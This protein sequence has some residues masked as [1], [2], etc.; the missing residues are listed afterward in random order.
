MAGE[1]INR[2]TDSQKQKILFRC[3][4]FEIALRWK[5]KERKGKEKERKTVFIQRL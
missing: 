4:C 3:C 5:G 1:F 2:L